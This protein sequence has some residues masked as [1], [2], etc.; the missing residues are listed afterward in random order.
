MLLLMCS[1]SSAEV[2]GLPVECPFTTL[3]I[4]WNCQYH[5][6]INLSVKSSFAYTNWKCLWT[7]TV[8][9][10]SAY[11]NT[12]CDFTCSDAMTELNSQFC[13]CTRCQHCHLPSVHNLE[14]FCADNLQRKSAV[15]CQLVMM[16]YSRTTAVPHDMLAQVWTEVKYHYDACRAVNGAH[17]NLHWMTLDEFP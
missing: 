12:H 14:N 3:P 4:S 2:Y 17:I 11:R 8:H 15:C 13:A 9:L 10:N 7:V 5:W 6:R 16:N 1:T